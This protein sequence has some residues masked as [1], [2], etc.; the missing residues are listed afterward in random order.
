[1]D[2]TVRPGRVIGGRYELLEPIG[3]GGFGRVWKARD[4]RLRTDVAVKQLV[5]PSSASPVEQEERLRR[6]ERE[7]LNAAK[8]RD[9]PHIV[10]VHDVVVEDDVPWIAMQLVVGRAL[11]ERL[12]ESGPLTVP[13]AT[14]V[15]RAMLKA[16]GAAHRAGIVHRDIKPANVLLGD[17]G[18]ILLTDFGIATHETDLTLTVTGSVIGS[19]PYMAPER[20]H[21]E[22]GQAPSDLF[23]L[24]VT[25]HEAVEG[26][27]PFGRNST[28]AALHAVAYEEP[29]PP[30]HAGT[31]TPLITLLLAKEPGDRPTVAE[32]LELLD[33]PDTAATTRRPVAVPPTVVLTKSVPAEAPPTPPATPIP[34]PPADPEP[35]PAPDPAATPASVPLAAPTPEALPTMTAVTPPPST[36]PTG[37]GV[38]LQ[39]H[40]WWAPPAPQPPPPAG[41]PATRW[42]GWAVAMALGVLVVV[43]VVVN[44]TGDSD[45][46][47]GTIAGGGAFENTTARSIQDNNTFESEIQ[48][49]G[50][51]GNAPSALEVTVDLDHTHLGDLELELLAPDGTSFDL[52]PFD[53][54]HEY[55]VDASAVTANGTWRLRVEDNASADTGTLNSWSLR[56][57]S[58]GSR[59]GEPQP[60]GGGIPATEGGTYRNGNAVVIQDRST[61]NSSI[62]VAGLAGNAPASLIV[63]VDLEHTY[64]GDLEIELFAPDGTSFDLEPY[65]EP[66][67]YTVDASAVPASGQWRLRVEDRLSS[68]T[69]TLNSWSLRFGPGDLQEV[70]EESAAG[71]GTFE[72]TDSMEI[73][74]RA[75][76]TS[77]IEVTG[78][79]GNAPGAL[80]V[81]VDID[82]SYIRDLDMELVAPDGSAFELEAFDEPHDYHIDASGVPANGTWELRIEDTLRADTGTLNAW[83][84]T[85]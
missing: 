45:D 16:L 10:S 1:M 28:P 69:G 73:E 11:S 5:L 82:H 8:L 68:D 31:L 40:G 76:V 15:A 44:Q 14:E 80:G 62:D 25:L 75:S 38:L 72:N 42:L 18:D 53:E 43:L 56:F 35:E 39:P 63:A 20:V 6:S 13:E 51:A 3:R 55:T 37:A 4:Q 34:T 30:E 78:L 81:W 47:P 58:G 2:H 57:G 9:H 65:D 33:N 71:G 83:S 41:S 54:P 24:G 29:P 74:D 84:L 46:D 59:N 48:V 21:G 60:E 85:F 77:P 36:G 12:R 27:S 49:T 22:K 66:H 52:E 50:V 67:E 23:S 61:V 64:L 19:A 17:N 79:T 32:A 7:V 70:G 26:A